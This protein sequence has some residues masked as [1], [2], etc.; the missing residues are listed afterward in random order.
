MAIC[1]SK[2]RPQIVAAGG[3]FLR[4]EQQPA[5][6]RVR[7]K[8]DDLGEV[9]ARRDVAGV[10]RNAGVPHEPEQSRTRQ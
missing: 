7:S 9:A 10:Y 6:L 8:S 2:T 1:E 4:L 5:L 3:L